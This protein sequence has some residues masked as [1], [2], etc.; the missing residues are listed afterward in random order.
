MTIR[1]VVADDEKPSRDRLVRLLKSEEDIE[2]VG[3]ASNGVEAVELINLHTPQLLFLDAQMPILDGFG[4]LAKI[5]RAL[6]PLTVFVTAYDRYAIQA[7]EAEALDY[8]L[9]PF[10]NQRLRAAVSRARKRIANNDAELGHTMSKLLNSFVMEQPRYLERAVIRKGARVH[11]V[12]VRDVDWIESAGDSVVFHIASE[13]Y[14]YSAGIGELV[15]HLDPKDFVRIHRSVIVNLNRIS[16]LQPRG[17]GDYGVIL[18]SGAELLLSRTYR[19]DLET[20][21]KQSL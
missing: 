14:K 4:T 2:I 19:P 16:E 6:M 20:A 12:E 10:S 8:L 9:K 15:R 7:F 17:H 5:D 13:T 11:F 3:E 1:T 21:L 18:S